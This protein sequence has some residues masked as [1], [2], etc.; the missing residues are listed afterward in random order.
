MTGKAPHKANSNSIHELRMIKC[1][2][3]SLEDTGMPFAPRTIHVI[4]SLLAFKPEER[5][6]SYDVAVDELRLA[7]G[8]TG[9]TVMTGISR[10]RLLAMVASGALLLA[11]GIGWAIKSLTTPATVNITTSTPLDQFN[12]NGNAKTVQGANVALS[13]SGAFVTVEDAMV[14]QAD[15][16][17]SNGVVHIIDRV[18][19]PP[20]K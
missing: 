2:R 14:T 5:P 17:A 8:L 11:Y 9:R 18:L 12:L 3:V 19:M 15:L 6:E 20:K 4:D 16:P 10:R 1:R 13:K 7:E